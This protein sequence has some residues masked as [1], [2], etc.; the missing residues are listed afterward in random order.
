MDAVT[1]RTR[2]E[3][4]VF[5][6]LW[7]L[8]WTACETSTAE[9]A[10]EKAAEAPQVTSDFKFNGRVIHPGCFEEMLTWISDTLPRVAAVDI[11]GCQE[12]NR[13]HAAPVIDDG[14]IWWRDEDQIGKGFFAY[15]HV[16]MLA[17][18]IHV[19]W[20]CANGGGSMV[21]HTLLF[22]RAQRVKMYYH[23][24]DRDRALLVC[25]GELSLGDRYAGTVAV[26]S[27]TVIVSDFGKNGE[28]KIMS[29]SKY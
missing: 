27:N 1:R 6:T 26:R 14:W 23:G 3:V 22:V 2:G 11:A 12:S 20:T 19:V 17:N 5:V 4:M 15:K 21:F 10:R 29:L 18:G 25:V 24:E 9:V 13:H 28:D 7:A 16:G 8:L